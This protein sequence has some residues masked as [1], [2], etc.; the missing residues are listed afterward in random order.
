MT[1]TNEHIN[2]DEHKDGTAGSIARI[3]HRQAFICFICIR[4]TYDCIESIKN[5][6]LKPHSCTSNLITNIC[7]LAL[8]YKYMNI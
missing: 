7:E 4:D 5:N 6:Q 1:Q 2:G 8:I 3:A